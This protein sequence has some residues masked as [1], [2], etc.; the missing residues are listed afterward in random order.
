MVQASLLHKCDASPPGYH[1]VVASV[2]CFRIFLTEIQNIQEGG[3]TN[4]ATSM[5]T[6]RLLWFKGPRTFAPLGSYPFLFW[7]LTLCSFGIL[8]DLTPCFFST[9][10][11]C[12]FR[13][14]YCLALWF[15]DLTPCSVLK[16]ASFPLKFNGWIAIFERK[17]LFHLFACEISWVHMKPHSTWIP[18]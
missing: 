16:G 6:C 9:L 10:C 17:H 2:E 1:L 18:T 12:F 14:S 7:H 3:S 11:F 15:L 8:P 4:H 5:N 13:G